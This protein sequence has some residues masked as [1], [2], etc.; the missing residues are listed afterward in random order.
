MSGFNL[1]RLDDLR[2]FWTILRG[3]F[4]LS[5]LRNRDLREALRGKTSS[6]ISRLLLRMRTH[7]LIKKIGRTHKYYVTRF[8]ERVLLAAMQVREFIIIPSLA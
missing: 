1:L 4:K 6:Q 2:L 8:G 7:G 5:G 3:E